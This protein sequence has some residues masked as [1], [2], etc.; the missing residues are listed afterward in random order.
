MNTN[1]IFDSNTFNIIVLGIVCLIILAFV[2]GLGVFVG[3]K[4]AEFSFNWADQYHRN[5]GGPQ[6][7]FFGEFM[8]TDKELPNAN[9]SFG[10]IIKIDGS[11][12]TVK[13]SDGDNT[14]KT[15]LV[16]DKTI[17]VLQRKNIKLSDLKTNDNIVV[18]GEPNSSGQIQADLIRVM[19][20]K[21]QI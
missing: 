8:G 9:G 7:G 1:N 10:Q 11:I 16:G 5:F 6:G 20:P 21:P 18:V 3:T 2:F 12:L 13:D 17:I 15:I 14:E 4:K 19:P